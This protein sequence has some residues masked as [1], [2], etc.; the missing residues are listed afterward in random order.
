MRLTMVIQLSTKE[1]RPFS[2]TKPDRKPLIISRI[3]HRSCL[4]SARTSGLYHMD[5][6]NYFDITL[7]PRRDISIRR[8]QVIASAAMFAASCL[9]GRA[10]IINA[11]S[12]ALADV[13][14]AVNSAGDGDT[15]VIP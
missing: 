14:A 10:A 4:H 12:P 5:S 9:T 15:V 6:I 3:R 7:F 13:T 11:A 2:L 8:L 1:E